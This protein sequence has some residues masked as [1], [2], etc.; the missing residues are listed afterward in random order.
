MN[1]LFQT[2]E[3]FIASRKDLEE[4]AVKDHAR[5]LVLSDSHGNYKIFL[6]LLKQFGPECDALVFCGDGIGDLAEI[7]ELAQS[8]EELK[9]IIPPV[10]AFVRGNGDP[11]TFPVSYDVGKYNPK[12]V[13]DQYKGTLHVPASQVLRANNTNF[14]ICHGHSFG[15]YFGIDQLGL[16]VKY[17]ECSFG[18][19]GHT[20]IGALDTFSDCKL[21]NPGSCS[22]PRGGDTASCA[23]I[24]V[25]KKFTDV[26]FIKIQ[27]AYG[28]K[29]E[30]KVQ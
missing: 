26:A 12:S 23:I 25:E 27:N 22:R 5:I 28:D 7:L 6:K 10:I 9:Q 18:I 19:Y 16:A 2:E 20:H 14:Y 4:L 15:V 30:F 8:D 3:G 29:L 11:Q 1:C 17:N 24:T 21:L 13:N